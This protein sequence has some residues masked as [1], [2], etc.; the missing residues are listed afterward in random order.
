MLL[1][2]RA[3]AS[4]QVVEALSREYEACERPDYIQGA[5]GRPP[6]TAGADGRAPPQSVAA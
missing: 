3:S 4:L 6:L 1:Q 5:S 2:R